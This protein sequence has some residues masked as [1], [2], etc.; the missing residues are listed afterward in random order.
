M[1]DAR[2]DG[3]RGTVDVVR[4]CSHRRPGCDGTL[5]ADTRVQPSPR[6]GDRAVDLYATVTF[7]CHWLVGV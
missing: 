1:V 3:N 2:L 4:I 5:V 6:P 7:A